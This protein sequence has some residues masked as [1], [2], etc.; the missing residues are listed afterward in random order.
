[1][2]DLLTLSNIAFVLG[3]LGMIFTVFNYF[4]DPQTELDKRQAVD[5]TQVDG[6]AALLAQQV[7]YDKESTERRFSEMGSRIENA[8]TLA[9][10]HIHTVDTKVEVLNGS[11]NGMAREVVRLSTIIEERMPK[12][13][14][15]APQMIQA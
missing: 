6:K 8:M 9:Q 15:S 14:T 4:K 2:S 3:L 5:Q 10:N 7:Q 12:N 11:V 1:M 13:I